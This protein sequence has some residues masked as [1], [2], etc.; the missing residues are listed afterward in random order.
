MRHKEASVTLVIWSAS[1]C[2]RVCECKHRQVLGK[3]HAEENDD[4]D[5][6]VVSAILNRDGDASGCFVA[7]LYCA[8][9]LLLLLGIRYLELK[10]IWKA[11]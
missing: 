1:V 6:G 11:N 2:A 9:S 4:N 3:V 7:G 8:T 10:L 5:V